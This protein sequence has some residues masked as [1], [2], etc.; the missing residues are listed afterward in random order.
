LHFERHI[1]GTD[2]RSFET[3]DAILDGPFAICSII[4]DTEGRPQDCRFLRVSSCFEDTTGFHGIEGHTLREVIP[5]VEQTWIDHYGRVALDRV[6]ARFTEASAFTGREYEVRAAPLD[7]PGRF[8]M[9]FRDVTEIRL[10]EAERE[11]ALEHA[12]H[13]LKELGHRV[14]NSFATISAILSM[15]ARATPREHRAALE[16]VQGR[17]QAL[18]ALYRRLDGAS[19]VDRIEM[20]E[21]LGGLVASFRDSLAAPAPVEVSCD[22]A[23][24]TLPSRA[25]VPLALVVNEL[26][27][28]AIKH[29]F[30]EGRT[31][32]VHVSLTAQDG[33]CRLCVADDGRGLDEA[34]EG[35]GT[36]R[37]LIDAFLAELG[38]QLS[39]QTGPEGT[40]ITVDFPA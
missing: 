16:R 40:R 19:Q 32:T 25:A 39:I 30:V 22:L 38:G 17:V 14:M 34:R 29:A 13:L 35:S 11:Q 20:A 15:E 6:P 28:N 26:L 27:T 12:Q 23:P 21:Y 37:T 2:D 1:T 5:E 24:V 31:G 4:T 10:L 33:T 7:P 8:V 36:G 3:F 9:V 18:A